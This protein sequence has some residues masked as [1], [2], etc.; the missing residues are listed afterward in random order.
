MTILINDIKENQILSSY[1][2]A[3]NSD[4]VYTEMISKENFKNLSKENLTIIYETENMIFYKNRKF[5]I[6]E[7]DIIFCNAHFIKSLFRQLK[8]IKELTNI[9]LITHQT[10]IPITKKLYDTKPK[11]ISEWY[12]INIDTKE[13]NLI[14]IPLGVSNDYSPK[15]PK[16]REFKKIKKIESKDNKIYVNF[17]I[18]TN[19]RERFSLYNLYKNKEYFFVENPNL[20]MTEYLQKLNEN[21]YILCPWGN[22]YDTHRFWE[23][24]YV[25]SIP[26]T[27][28]HITYD[29][30]TLLPNIQVPN[31]KDIDFERM[32][33]IRLNFEESK[34]EY[35]KLTIDWWISKIKENKI[36]DTLKKSIEIN[37]ED[38][39]HDKSLGDLRKWTRVERRNKKI[40]LYFFK[41]FKLIYYSFQ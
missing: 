29:S 22:G 10:D 6:K 5:E 23:S 36:S 39:L 16:Y 11:C 25:G 31:Y 38:E 34:F 28:K 33:N 3:R 32:D 7:N 1:N 9:K 41:V 14:P 37:E 17:E 12:S 8:N 27:K 35:E 40:K 24:I 21:L 26:I 18:N 19:R 20:T 30:A 2:F 4:V 15:N 13:K